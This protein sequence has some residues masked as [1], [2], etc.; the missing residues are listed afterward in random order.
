MF[1]GQTERFE[2]RLTAVRAGSYRVNYSVSPGLY[3]R[4]VPA[5]GQNTTGTFDVV[6]SGEPV[7]ARVNDEGEVVRGAAPAAAAQTASGLGA[8]T[9]RSAKFERTSTT[10]GSLSSTSKSS[11]S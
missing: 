4:A 8:F 10:C 5:N 7:P 3:G 1:P 9:V 11:R 2:W 6:I